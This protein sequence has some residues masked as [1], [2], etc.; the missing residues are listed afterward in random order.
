MEQWV[1]DKI[2]AG[3]QLFFNATADVDEAYQ[4]DQELKKP[5]PLLAKAAMTDRVLDL[6]K[7]FYGLNIDNDFLSIS[8]GARAIACIRTGPFR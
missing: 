2:A 4:T 3:R 7:D 6:P 5:Q 8:I 1:K